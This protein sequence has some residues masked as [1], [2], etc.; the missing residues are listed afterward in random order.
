MAETELIDQTVPTSTTQELLRIIETLEAENL[1]NESSAE[2][3]KKQV[4]SGQIVSEDDIVG[5]VN[6]LVT[7]LEPRTG[8]NAAIQEQVVRTE[9]ILQRL[10]LSTGGY[11]WEA[12]TPNFVQR[13]MDNGADFF[14][15][16]GAGD[17]GG[18]DSKEMWR[19]ILGGTTVLATDADKDKDKDEEAA[20]D[21]V[22]AEQAAY[23][24]Q[25][26]RSL[27]SQRIITGQ[28]YQELVEDHGLLLDSTS[29]GSVMEQLS[30]W[31]ITDSQ[32][33]DVLDESTTAVWRRQNKA[34][35]LEE[36]QEE[37]GRQEQALLGDDA[38]L[39]RRKQFERL[40]EEFPGRY[41]WN[42]ETG[43]IYAAG[44]GQLVDATGEDVLP[45]T[46]GNLPE[47]FVEG[48]DY[49]SEAVDVE[50]PWMKHGVDV[51]TYYDL[52][53]VVQ[54]PDRYHA[55]GL[56][57]FASGQKFLGGFDSDWGVTQSEWT[58]K[59][60]QK[61]EIRFQEN[62]RKYEYSPGGPMSFGK[63]E[64]QAVRRPWYDQMDQW[65]LFAGKSPEKIAEDQQWLVSLGALTSDD[66][67]EGT[68]GKSEADAMEKMMF[69]A[70]GQAERIE[71]IDFDYWQ[72]Y[73]KDDAGSGINRAKFSA[74]AYRTLD[75]ARIQLTIEDTVRRSLGR[76]AS[77]S[78]LADLGTFLSDQHRQSFAA[79]VQAMEAEYTADTRAIDGER[80]AA[81]EVADVDYEARYQQ[82]FNETHSAE[83]DR[84]SRTQ[85]VAER[86]QLI[87]GALNNFMNQLGGGIGGG[88]MGGR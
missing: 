80:A 88:S 3:W 59:A 29:L 64:L 15:R 23:K 38:M 66:I 35:Q 47:G 39:K 34:M 30:D 77:S 87:G 13:F 75:P 2:L 51:E 44:T 43:Y 53:D 71:D 54:N 31:G 21:D 56:E 62:V 82:Q 50:Q 4:R 49:W 60:Q 8:S 45:D 70:N 57:R 9:E 12:R 16:L 32:L 86:Q 22:L 84:Y 61:E 46:Q 10:D 7:S 85:N 58:Q 24:K 72:D 63:P 36:D 37:L 40:D 52:Y 42:P 79:D 27:L 28:Q 68:W 6:K 5:R 14:E 65:A 78:E 18:I 26:A 67:T 73:W 48:S 55:G 76:D 11:R 20:P 25:F 83:L 17:V 33:T 69:V 19:T 1:L 81:G 41:V 74:P